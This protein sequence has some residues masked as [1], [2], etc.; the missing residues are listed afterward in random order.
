VPAADL[1]VPSIDSALP[2]AMPIH[3]LQ[4]CKQ[5]RKKERTDVG[6]SRHCVLV[7]AFISWQDIFMY[8]LIFA[9]PN[10]F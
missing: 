2:Q 7:P 5:A 9:A 8:N 1:R 4:A 6:C 3:S 10:P